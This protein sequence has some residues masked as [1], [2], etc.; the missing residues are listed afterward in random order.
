[1]INVLKPKFRTEEIL[2]EIRTC[3][4]KGWTGIG[5][6][7]EEFEKE[8]CRFT[9][10]ANSHFLSSNTVGLHLALRVLRLTEGW[11][12][13]DEVITTPFT[14][15]S[16][17]HAILYE[18]FVP[19]FAD[20]DES[21]CL[22][23]NSIE[24]CITEKTKAVI[25]VGIGGNAGQLN[26][27]ADL[28]KKYNLKLILDAA[29]MA[30]TRV[31]TELERGIAFGVDHVGKEADVSVFSFQAVKNLPTG[32][33][34]MICF[35]DKDLDALARKLSWLGI[36]KDTYSRSAKGS[37]KWKY[38]VDEIGFK[39]HGNSIM[40]AI[41]LVQLKYLANDN[42]YRNFLSSLYNENL[43]NDI[44]IIQDSSYTYLS[45]KHLF[46]IR[47]GTRE[48]VL[49]RLYDE[50]IY[51]GV[52]YIPNTEFPMYSKSKHRVPGATLAGSEVLSLPLHLD[53]AEE[54]VLK[55]CKIINIHG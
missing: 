49:D 48:K 54:D 28:C 17:N 47:L 42:L 43:K 31:R 23:P 21:L 13:G 45:S 11:N 38:N 39:Y 5:Y 2:E 46:Q 33:S 1:M 16:T 30:G 22:D 9:G 53:L 26:R 24:K 55:V 8:W 15:V 37:Y 35:Q 19:V 12:D 20:I 25:F 41:G 51:P 6:K 10:L 14:F 4:D 44:K 29:H 27:V 7:T 40:A 3:L 34:G 18:R 52:H 32:D 36:N 50:D